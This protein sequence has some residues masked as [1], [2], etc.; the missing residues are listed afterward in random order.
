MKL[1]KGAVCEV[2]N[3]SV[4]FGSSTESSS[5]R[6]QQTTSMAFQSFRAARFR[7][8]R[9]SWYADM[10]RDQFCELHP[11]RITQDEDF[12]AAYTMRFRMV[13]I[14]FIGRIRNLEELSRRLK[15]QE[16]GGRLQS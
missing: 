4:F 1:N 5:A 11:R 6:V 7:S 14:F 8:L 15:L 13:V 16:P 12:G 3:A 2:D 9:R 10:V